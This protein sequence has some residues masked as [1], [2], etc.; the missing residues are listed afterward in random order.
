MRRLSGNNPLSL[1]T[2]EA[3][4]STLDSISSS[5][6]LSG[7][8]GKETASNM[9]GISSEANLSG[10]GTGPKR[11]NPLHVTLMNSSTTQESSS[12]FSSV[13]SPPHTSNSSSQ[14]SRS[15]HQPTATQSNS[16]GVYN[17]SSKQAQDSASS[18]FIEVG[19]AAIKPQTNTLLQ[20]RNFMN[21]LN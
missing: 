21:Y 18:Q 20:D 15:G 12:L 2:A 17:Y 4:D 6:A 16:N 3:Y 10:I 13:L 9:G 11:D 5:C 8:N 1:G 7:G 19:G 14:N